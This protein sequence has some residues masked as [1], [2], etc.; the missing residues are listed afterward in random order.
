MFKDRVFRAALLLLLCIAGQ[1]ACADIVVGQVAPLSGLDVN[2]GRAYSAGMQAYFDLVNRS[3]GIH[4]RSIALVVRD[5]AGRA[6]ETVAATRKLLAESKPV[7]LAGYFGARNLAELAKSGLLET[8]RIALVGYRTSEVQPD[9]ALL[10][11]VRAGLK[12]EL[13]KIAEHLGTVAVTRLALLYEEGP[14]SAEM[15]AAMEDAVA[16]NKSRLVATAGYEAGSTRVSAAVTKFMAAN[17]QAVVVVASGSA[18]AAFIEQYR[19]AGG[20]AMLFA[21]SAA[22]VEQLSRRLGDEQLQGVAI[23]Q[24]TPSPY[25]VS[26]RIAK[27]LVDLA[28]KNPDLTQHMSFATIEGFIAAKVIVEAMRRAGSRTLTREAFISGLN[29]LD[30]LDLGGYAVS[31]RGGNRTGSR[32]VE[33]SI[34]SS[35]GRIRQ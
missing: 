20:S 33:L 11:N 17:P 16:R 34:V 31:Y 23:A 35:T 12:D 22:D 32:F 3:G 21:N 26:S 1:G 13:E 15:I 5:D 28:A 19:T 10:Y 30:R 2:Q 6:D 14:G 8:D 27:E 24:V 25:R 29:S 9:S 7:V 18:A 4:G